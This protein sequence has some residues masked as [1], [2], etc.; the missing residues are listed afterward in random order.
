MKDSKYSALEFRHENISYNFFM[1][2]LLRTKTI[3][4]PVR[5]KRVQRLHLLNRIEEGT[6]RA[7]TLVFAPAGF[8][9]TTLVVDWAHSTQLSVAWLSLDASDRSTEQFLPYLIQALQSIQEHTGQTALALLHSGQNIPVDVVLST[10]LNDLSEISLDFAVILDDYHACDGPDV[11]HIMQFLLEHCP[12]RMHLVLISRTEPFLNLARL[13]ATDQIV[14][15]GAADLRFTEHEIQTFLEDVLDARPSSRQLAELSQSTEGWAVALQLAGMT[16]VRQPAQWRMPAGQA[17]IFDYLAGEVFSREKAEVQ[18]F[19]QVTAQ[20]ERFC[21]PLCEFLWSS[22]VSSSTIDE[23][24]VQISLAQLPG[25]LLTHVERANLFLVPLDAGS[26]WFRYHALFTDFLRRQ[27]KPGQFAAILIAAVDW[28]EKNGLVEDAIQLAL[29]MGENDRAVNLIESVY[30]DLLLHGQQAQ[31][32]K[33]LDALPPEM[34]A[35]RPRLALAKGWSGVILFDMVMASA[36]AQQAECNIPAGEGNEALRG[37]LITMRIL[38]DAFQGKIPSEEEYDE[39]FI[40]LAEQDDFLHCL[41]HF[42]QGLSHI[43]KAETAPALDSMAEAMRLADKL[44]NHLVFIVAGTQMGEQLQI[45]G[46]LQKAERV[47]NQVI[48]YVQETLGERSPLQGMPF[49]SYADLLRETNRLD[50]AIGYANQ[51]IAYCQLWQ[52]MA[53]MDGWLTLAHLEAGRKNWVACYEH[54]EHAIQTAENTE[55]FLDDTF[56]TVQRVHAHLMQGDL[57]S[58]EHCLMLHHVEDAVPVMYAHLGDMAKLTFL[59][60]DLLR[61]ERNPDDITAE[62]MELCAKLEA[63]ERTSALIEAWILTAYASDL[64]GKADQAAAAL[65]RAFSLSAQC[66]FIRLLAD[67]GE[68]TRRLLKKYRSKLNA[69]A[70]Y[71]QSISQL[72]APRDTPHSNEVEVLLPLTRRELDVLY[73][74]AAGMSNQEIAAERVLTLNTVKKHVA[75]ILAKLGV[76]N[77]TQAAI[78]AKKNGWIA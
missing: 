60:A 17:H 23:P 73:L 24:I 58:A 62:L 10:L 68:P 37:E 20:F 22:N 11:A 74:L 34:L 42:N 77:R 71:V 54:F 57:V 49:V 7:L 44:D 36:A 45:H 25:E 13:R 59:R 1:L 4:P 9:K 43:L 72:A 70:A 66:G 19:L 32:L 52:P 27:S 41:L 75:N 29:R 21:L 46:E 76:A 63:R 53:S 39:A 78:L 26:A 18:A 65:N 3:L 40:L 67:E 8:G 48:H 28:F 61:A 50:E 12:P 2:Q 38:M 31:L 51:G 30:R 14:E 15:I 16:L 56:V 64:A 5:P 55:T 33:W 69:P 6:L 47:F 35:E